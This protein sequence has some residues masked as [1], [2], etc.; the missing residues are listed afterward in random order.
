MKILNI[1]SAC[2]I[3]LSSEISYSAKGL[4]NEQ[5]EFLDLFFEEIATPFETSEELSN[6][7]IEIVRRLLALFS[8]H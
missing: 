6:R 2:F 8:N 7:Q 5:R 4:L 1:P 3:D